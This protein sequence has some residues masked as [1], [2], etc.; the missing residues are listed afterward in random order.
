MLAVS[1]G[2]NNCQ[3]VRDFEGEINRV[4]KACKPPEKY[5]YPHTLVGPALGGSDRETRRRREHLPQLDMWLF[6]II[7]F[8]GNNI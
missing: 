2:L 1:E 7:S 5:G 3:I 8:V 4:A 6:L